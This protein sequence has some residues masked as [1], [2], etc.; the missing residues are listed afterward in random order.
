[1]PGCKGVMHLVRSRKL[2]EIGDDWRLCGFRCISCGTA[3]NPVIQ[4]QIVWEC[5][6][7]RLPNASLSKPQHVKPAYLRPLSSVWLRVWGAICLSAPL[8][9]LRAV[10]LTWR[11]VSREAAKGHRETLLRESTSGRSPN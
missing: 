3:L 2:P 11:D 1:M 4:A 6:A 8:L 7:S 10:W 9:T 5:A